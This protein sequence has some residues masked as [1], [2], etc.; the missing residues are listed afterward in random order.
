MHSLV[1]L[2]LTVANDPNALPH[3]PSTVVAGELVFALRFCGVLSLG[4]IGVSM[5]FLLMYL[6]ACNALPPHL[7]LCPVHD[8]EPCPRA[9]RWTY[10]EEIQPHQRHWFLLHVAQTRLVKGMYVASISQYVGARGTSG[11]KLMLMSCTAVAICQMQTAWMLWRMSQLVH[12][13]AQPITRMVLMWAAAISLM[14]LGLAESALDWQTQIKS[15]KD[16]EDNADG[17]GM[18]HTPSFSFL[19][20]DSPTDDDSS[21]HSTRPPL[22]RIMSVYTEADEAQGKSTLRA[23]HMLAAFA[24]V[25]LNVAAQWEGPQTESRLASVVLVT[26]GLVSFLVFCIMQWLS[27]ANDELIP[28]AIGYMRASKVAYSWCAPCRPFCYCPP[29]FQNDPSV[30]PLLVKICDGCQGRAPKKQRVICASWWF[31]TV[32]VVAFCALTGTSAIEALTLRV[33]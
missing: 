28:D 13:E 15:K 16:D 1:L 7:N 33:T 9:V 29:G 5:G 18:A 22:K 27:G 32:E 26:V 10:P 4:V 19:A 12:G 30:D 3:T 25:G 8:T 2:L 11:A 23:V 31:I 24:V 21:E 20:Q 14:I 6:G 17:S